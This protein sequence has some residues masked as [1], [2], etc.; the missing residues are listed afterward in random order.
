V[1]E[2]RRVS[3]AEAEAGPPGAEL[4][5]ALS[6]DNPIEDGVDGFG[7]EGPPVGLGILGFATAQSASRFLRLAA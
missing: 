2:L 6:F 5:R 4:I 1:P 7:E 3:P